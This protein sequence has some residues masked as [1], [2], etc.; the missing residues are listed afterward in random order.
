MSGT[1]FSV[2]VGPGDP[3][4]LTL[5]A[6]R[7]LQ[8][9]S[10]IAAL[11][12]GETAGVAY[13]IAC[14]ALPNLREK[15]FVLLHLPMT[16]DAEKLANSRQTALCQL[17]ECL[18]QGQDV[19]LLTLGD[20][21]VYASSSYLQEMAAEQGYEVRMIAGVPSFCA[22]AALAGRSLTQGSEPLQIL[23]G[24]YATVEEGLGRPGPKVLMKTGTKLAQVKQKLQAA[25]TLEHAVLIENCGMEGEKIRPLAEAD[26]SGYFSIILVD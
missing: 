1:L 3:E 2:G 10:V 7:V 11:A 19:A 6:V 15:P 9:C 21:S 25:G 22:A 26:E 24:S 17:T 8:E 13:E 14:A 18:E 4:L 5:K 16:R 20:P 12:S 23:P